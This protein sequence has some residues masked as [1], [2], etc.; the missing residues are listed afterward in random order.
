M[1]KLKSF[2]NFAVTDPSTSSQSKQIIVRTAG[3]RLKYQRDTLLLVFVIVFGFLSLSIIT[4]SRQ[5]L[6]Y[7]R[8][9]HT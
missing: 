1:C 4:Y 7:L 8:E 2:L 5:V 3:G 6:L 9:I